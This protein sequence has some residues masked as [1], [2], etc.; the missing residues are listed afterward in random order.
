MLILET[1]ILK[2]YRTIISLGKLISM[3][4]YDKMQKI[5]SKQ[6]SRDKKFKILQESLN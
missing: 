2:F 6:R 1:L 5:E 3:N 4:G